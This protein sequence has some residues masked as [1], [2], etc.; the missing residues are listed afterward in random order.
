M[1]SQQA[2]TLLKQHTSVLEEW[3]RSHCSETEHLIPLALLYIHQRL[4]EQ[5]WQQVRQ[6]DGA[7]P[8]VEFVR[9]LVEDAL[10]TF[11]H[12]IWFGECASTIRFWLAH[13]GVNSENIRQ[14]AEDYVKNH[15]TK[16]NFARFRSYNKDKAVNFTTYLSR[17][18]RNLLID[19]LRK[20]KPL[21]TTETF[22][23]HPDEATQLNNKNAD[24]NTM[25]SHRQLHLKE[26]GQWFFAGTA[27][28]NDE[29]TPTLPDIPDKIK[30]S[31]K[32][33]LFL[34]AM[35]KD[36]MSAEEA[37]RLPGINMGKWQAHGF[38]RRI[39]A[40]IKK[41]LKVMGYESLQSLLY[42]N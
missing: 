27:P 42:S 38:H 15:L 24:I 33:R 41:L 35:Y 20:K 5:D 6:Y 10:E 1:D 17:V 26:I 23:N 13:Y 40:R 11:S 36:G 21:A 25:E 7:Q 4:S 22:E 14:D 39:K 18:I 30:L 3:V 28:Q 37:G 29:A 19:Y 32:E 9:E 8:F 2:K 16:D 34:R 12:G 31:H